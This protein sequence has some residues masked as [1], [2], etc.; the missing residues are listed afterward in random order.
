MSLVVEIQSGF[1]GSFFYFGLK[2]SSL[3]QGAFAKLF[4]WIFL[5]PGLWLAKFLN[6]EKSI[7]QDQRRSSSPTFVVLDTLKTSHS[8]LWWYLRRV[9]QA[10]TLIS[11][12]ENRYS[13]FESLI[14]WNPK[15]PLIGFIEDKTTFTIELL[16]KFSEDGR[17]RG[18]DFTWL[19]T[20][21]IHGTFQVLSKSII[22]KNKSEEVVVKCIWTSGK[23]IGKIFEIRRHPALSENS[24]TVTPSSFYYPPKLLVFALEGLVSASA[25]LAF[26]ELTK[27]GWKQLFS[28]LSGI[29]DRVSLSFA[30]EYIMFVFN[31]LS[32]N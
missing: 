2:V 28:F 13:L 9:F 6:A 5:N 21:N 26:I 1:V 4:W 10:N 17:S 20:H 22:E 12:V 27:D 11:G 30:I 31:W 16:F 15:V 18:C 7:P 8:L 14:G 32:G 29:W 19:T 23:D 25:V 3:I 24:D